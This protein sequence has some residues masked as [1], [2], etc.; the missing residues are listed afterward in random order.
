MD[1]NVLL[2]RETLSYMKV[3]IKVS[4]LNTQHLVH[5]HLTLASHTHTS[6]PPGLSAVGD[7]TFKA[8]GVHKQHSPLQSTTSVM[9]ENQPF[10]VV[11]HNFEVDAL[12]GSPQSAGLQDS[13]GGQNSGKSNKW[14]LLC[15]VSGGLSVCFISVARHTSA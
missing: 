5:P 3:R 9:N 8:H 15:V 1:D 7:L 4:A 2:W 6:Q 12:Q 13:D 11:A 10:V 14:R